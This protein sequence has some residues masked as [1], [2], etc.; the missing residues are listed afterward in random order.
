MAKAK[1]V[2]V[3]VFNNSGGTV[4]YVSQLNRITR[5]WDKD[6][7]SKLISVEELKDLINSA[8]G[9]QLLNEDLLVKDVA[10]REELGLPTEEVF[11]LD[12]N[13]IEDLLFNGSI[14]ELREVLATASQTV[15]DKIVSISVQKDLADMHKIEAIDEALGTQLY[16]LIKENKST[17]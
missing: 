3:E 11:L 16:N 1:E 17:I 9:F 13:K 8:G 7:T 10:I 15:K 12:N 14:E 5:R 2:M 4:L 6:N